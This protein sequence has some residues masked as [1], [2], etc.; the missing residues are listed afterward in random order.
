M[1]AADRG[2][3]NGKFAFISQSPP[4]PHPPPPT[5]SFRPGQVAGIIAEISSDQSSFAIIV[6]ASCQVNRYRRVLRVRFKAV[7]LVQGI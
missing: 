1:G 7:L 2:W 5:M 3:L 4:P 6:E